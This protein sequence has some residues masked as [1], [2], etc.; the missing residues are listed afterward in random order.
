VEHIHRSTLKG[1]LKQAFGFG[2]SHPFEL[3]YFTPGRTILAAPFLDVNKATPG[4]W[5]WIDLNQA[6]KKLLLSL[7]PGLFWYPLYSLAIIYFIYL[8]FFVH[9]IGAQR[10]V[11]TKIR[12]L[13]LL[14]LLLLLKSIALG[15]GRFV[16]SFKHKVL[17]V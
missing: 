11:L 12:E 10:N 5:I 1:L 16:Y 2:S 7:I 6:D 9:K 4:N 13:P 8:C 14:S 3:K 17:C 15:T